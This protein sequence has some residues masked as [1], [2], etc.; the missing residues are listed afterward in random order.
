M[1]SR[2][3]ARAPERVAVLDFVN[4]FSAGLG[5]R[6]AEG[7]WSWLHWGRNINAEHHLPPEQLLGDVEIL[8]E[9]KIGINSLPLR[10]LYGPYIDANFELVRGTPES[11]AYRRREAAR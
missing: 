3:S 10:D 2:D 6:P 8:M 7:D 4:P 5:P 9:P 1:S 11:R